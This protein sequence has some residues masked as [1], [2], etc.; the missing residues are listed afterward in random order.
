MQF[1]SGNTLMHDRNV[2]IILTN[3]YLECTKFDARSSA[4][5]D[6]CNADKY[7]CGFLIP[8]MLLYDYSGLLSR[9]G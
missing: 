1:L 5:Y 3:V 6:V 2:V 7:V 4:Q 9:Y 8:Y